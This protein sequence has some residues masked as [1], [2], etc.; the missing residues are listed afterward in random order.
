MRRT[1]RL[2][3]RVVL[4]DSESSVL[5]LSTR[6]LS[7]D[8][9]PQSWE[10]PGGGLAPGEAPLAGAIREM[11]EETGI[12]L[13]SGDLNGPLWRRDVIY[14]YRGEHRLQHETIFTAK[15]GYR[16]PAIHTAGR[17]A[18]ELEDHQ[19]YRWWTIEEVRAAA[20]LFYPRSLPLH[21][22]ALAA[23]RPVDEP[24]EVWDERH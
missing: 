9:F 8:N 11:L 6:D 14:T 10:I 17:E 16:A 18:F 21:I 15:I 5:L 7:N 24:L 4:F 2:A 19:N 3:V 23:G 13:H 22:A 20:A 12:A 1:E